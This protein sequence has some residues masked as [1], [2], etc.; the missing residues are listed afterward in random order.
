MP[1]REDSGSKGPALKR[2]SGRERQVLK[3][4]VEGKSDSE[5]AALLQVAPKSVESYRR[6]MMEKLGIE[7]LP[8]LVKF[9][10]RNRHNASVICVG[11]SPSNAQKSAANTGG[12]QTQKRAREAMRLRSA[13]SKTSLLRVFLARSAE[14]LR[15][16]R[17]SSATSENATPVPTSAPVRM[18]FMGLRAYEPHASRAVR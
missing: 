2:L 18:M 5:I 12:I 6:R 16:N 13:P 11:V 4:V 1:P 14:L 10:I 9:A 17:Y 7:D 15:S 3:F 8:S